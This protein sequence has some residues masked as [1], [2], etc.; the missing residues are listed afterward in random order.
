MIS[1]FLWQ[2]FNLHF[3]MFKFLTPFPFTWDPY[4]K[5]LHRKFNRKQVLHSNVVV[6][7]FVIL[8]SSWLLYFLTAWSSSSSKFSSCANS[9]MFATMGIA[10]FA[11]I[12]PIS[13]FAF[14]YTMKLDE[15]VAMFNDTIMKFQECKFIFTV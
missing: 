12:T 10:Q 4:L 15:I 5:R 1:D 14:F 6:Y 3:R 8:N 9:F 7:Y 13:A 2:A 11:V